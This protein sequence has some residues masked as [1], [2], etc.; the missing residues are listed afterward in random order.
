MFSPL[1]TADLDHILAHTE[2]L[3]EPLRGEHVFLS[4]GT[5]FFGHWLVESFLHVNRALNLRASL[6][7]LS[8]A[9]EK[10]LGNAPHLAGA[11]G[12]QLLAGDVRHFDFPPGEFGCVIHAATAASQKLTDNDPR[13]MLSTIVDGTARMIALAQSHGT[14]RFLLTSSGAVYGRQPDTVE[15]VRE[16]YDGAPDP[17]VAGTVYGQGKRMAEHLCALAAREGTVQYQIARCFA[18]VGPHLPLDAHFA[19]GNF[20]GDALAGRPMH[21]QGDGRPLRS[22]LYA[23]DLAIW[24]WTI[25]L[26]GQSL[27]AYNVGS[28]EAL[29]IRALAKT[30]QQTLGRPEAIEVRQKTDPLAPVPR[31]V[32]DTRRARTE[33]GLAA[34]I[35]LPEALRRTA[36]WHTDV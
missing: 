32:P 9:P 16:D 7:V 22:Y 31:Y 10:F 17:L 27:R 11:E 26:E 13:A 8:R 24:L 6:T 14:R 21:I 25:L 20:L 28:E 18:F 33:L 23:A 15:R 29:S 5:G 34:W 2:R 30:V 4:G 1:A 12:L 35:D 3:W 19:V 36:R